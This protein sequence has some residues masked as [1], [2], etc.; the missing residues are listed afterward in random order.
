V[1]VV[2]FGAVAARA[3]APRHP[4]GERSI[5]GVAKRLLARYNRDSR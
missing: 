4:Y 5:E 2:A 1:A 3:E